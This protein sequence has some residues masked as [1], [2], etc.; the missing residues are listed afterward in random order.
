MHMPF[1]LIVEEVDA[2]PNAL[3]HAG[4]AR[5]AAMDSGGGG[6]AGPMA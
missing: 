5:R 1:A 3:A 2:A 6:I 4:G